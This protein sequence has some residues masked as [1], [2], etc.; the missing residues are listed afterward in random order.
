MIGAGL[1]TPLSNYEPN[2]ILSIGNQTTAGQGNAILQY[3]FNSGLFANVQGG[4]QF[5][6]G[7]VP[8]ASIF[9]AMVGF[10][11]AEIYVAGFLFTQTSDKDAPDIMPPDVPFQETR[12]NY[13]AIGLNLFVL[14]SSVVGISA[15]A[16]KYISGRNVG[17][18][19]I[20]S[21]GVNIRFGQ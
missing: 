15:S 19:N 13:T 2:A 11:A 18:S 20:F 17:I 21:G 1:T 4:Y 7:E 16:S 5:K 9:Q 8:N 3:K 6:S 10:A 14:L 12:V